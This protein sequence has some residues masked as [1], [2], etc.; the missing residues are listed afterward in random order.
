MWQTKYVVYELTSLIMNGNLTFDNLST[1]LI[2]NQMV[3]CGKSIVNNEPNQM[4][5]YI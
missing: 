5:S 1:V 2:F 4:A 3:T